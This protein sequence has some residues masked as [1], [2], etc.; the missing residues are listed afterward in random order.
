MK[1]LF[2]GGGTGG[3]FYPLIAVAEALHDIVR[4][5]KLIEPKLYYAAP[6]KYD[7]E[8]LLGNDITFIS[9][10]AGKIRN[11]FSIR[12]F[13]DLFKTGWGVMHAIIVMFFLYPD[14]VFGK[15]G[16]ASFPT[17]VA[18]KLFRIPVVLHESDAVPG[19]VNLW[20]GKFAEKIALSFDDAAK[21]F[22]KD[23]VALTG[24]PIRK[25]IV[26]PE[27]DGAA[28]FLKLESNLPVILVLG[29]SQGA[30][31]INEAILQALPQ[32]TERYQIIHQ[33]GEQN[34]DDAKGRLK[35]I[36]GT[37]SN[38][39]RYK[40]F[41][42]LNVL[43]LRMAAG[44]ASIIISR[45]GSTIFEIAS[46][47]VPSILVPIPEPTSHDQTRNAFAYARSG[48]CSVI[49]QNNLKSGVL[50]EEVDRIVGSP[51]VSEKMRAAATAFARPEAAR[52]I[53]KALLDI[54]LS[55]ESR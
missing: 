26:H 15:G 11:Y 27:K 36:L 5:E 14:V 31:A 25:S 32:L 34:I 4:E 35:V 17:L 48:A 10:S 12:N 55:H 3:H 1:I 46:W 52:T 29:G 41:A 18:A 50:V 22:P 39:S 21:Y 16:Y 30:V 43:A 54:G 37:S 24:N 7:E 44:V 47:G 33:T 8:M 6:D 51:E 40:P 2:T 9:M 13:F 42:Y 38:I 28:E 23:R 45:A 53:A 20:A 19:R 49:E